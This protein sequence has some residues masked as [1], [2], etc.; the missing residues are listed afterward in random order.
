M[1]EYELNKIEGDRFLYLTY[2]GPLE[3]DDINKIISAVKEEK[4]ENI[5]GI[6]L[7]IIPKDFKYWGEARN[8]LIIKMYDIFNIV[9]LYD[10]DG[11]WC[12]IRKGED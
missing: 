3:D 12:E 9:A 8:K 1:D 4:N 11:W 6:R 2:R 7:K 10:G 5:K